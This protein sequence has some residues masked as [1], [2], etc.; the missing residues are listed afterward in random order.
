MDVLRIVRDGDK[1][2][3]DVVDVVSVAIARHVAVE[4]VFKGGVVDLSVLIQV[5]DC[6]CNGRDA[7]CPSMGDAV[8]DG[9][10]GEG[11]G[12]AVWVGD[13]CQ[14]AVGVVGV[15]FRAF[16]GGLRDAFA[17]GVVGV[18]EEGEPRRARGARPTVVNPYRAAEDV[19]GVGMSARRTA[20]TRIWRLVS[21]PFT[22]SAETDGNE[23]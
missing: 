7:R 6:V 20:P 22:Y 11:F 17:V 4:V 12:G 8:T 3:E 16:G 15:G 19:V 13:A 23:P 18:F 1:A 2:V 10:V 5:V 14:L 21:E 9:I